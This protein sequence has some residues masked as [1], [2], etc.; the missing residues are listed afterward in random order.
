[1]FPIAA[2][3][4]TQA[5]A[6]AVLD[7]A[8]DVIAANVALYGRRGYVEPWIGYLAVDDSGQ[9][10][11]SCGFTGPPVAGEV[12]LAYFSFPGFEGRGIATAMATALMSLAQPAADAGAIRYIAHTLPEEG[13]SPSI[14]RK[15]G[16]RCA[17][18]I[19]HPEDGTVWKWVRD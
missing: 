9:I 16:F 2:D 17:G 11:G 7:V 13:P 10:V 18:P 8:V 6:A 15:L 1:M 14:L 3:G 12:E 19:A 4:Q 5:P